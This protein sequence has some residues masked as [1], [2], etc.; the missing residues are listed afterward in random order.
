MLAKII[1]RNLHNVKSVASSFGNVTGQAI[2][3]DLNS[4]LNKMDAE[5]Y[6]YIINQKMINLPGNNNT[7][8]V[9]RKLNEYEYFAS[10]V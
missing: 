7:K 4:D 1:K 9:D 3:M 2:V 8:Q 6:N 10:L 5:Y